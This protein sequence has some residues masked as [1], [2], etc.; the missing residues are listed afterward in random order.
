MR[1]NSPY[2]L[3]V[4]ALFIASCGPKQGNMPQGA[5]APV[6][7]HAHQ[8]R[9]DVVSLTEKYPALLVPLQEV[10]LRA[11]LSGVV[12]DIFF[13]DGQRVTAGQ[14]LYE[15]DR[16]NY[17]AAYNA[18][19][20][21]VQ[22]AKA[23]LEKSRKDALRYEEL[24]AKD[25]IAAQRLDYA[26]TDSSNAASQL[27]LAEANLMTAE[28]NLRRSQIVA[29][30]SGIIGISA[31]KKGAFVSP[32]TTL[33][34]TIST[35]DPM[36]A[37][38]S[39]NQRDIARFIAYQKENAQTVSDSIFRLVLGNTVYSYPGK[40]EIIDR[41]VNPGTGAISVRVAFPNPESE[42]IAGMNAS[43]MV[44]NTYPEAQIIIP[45]K[46]VSEQLGR[47]SVFVIGSDNK[48]ELRIVEIGPVSGDRIVILS[49]LQ[50]NERIAVDGIMN[51]R[52]GSDVL[53]AEDTVAAK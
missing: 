47:Y 3:F 27:A 53:I 10:E 22:V 20:A 37:D 26:L 11:E 44:K 43:L 9:K 18:A 35:I 6:E 12:T 4:F 36:T 32:G 48:A 13:K 5:S 50:E 19:K 39:V 41:A 34:N 46:A 52:H 8:V 29:P 31:V 15:I 14:K 42:L 17:L 24:S 30:F 25:A 49:G 21:N 16:T 38:I 7:V 23:N 1:K 33:L 2:V 51:L 40:I 45:H 28:A